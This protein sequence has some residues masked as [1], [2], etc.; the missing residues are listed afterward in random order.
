MSPAHDGL[1]SARESFSV[2]DYGESAARQ[3]RKVGARLTTREDS[4]LRAGAHRA[5]RGAKRMDGIRTLRLKT[6]LLLAVLWIEGV[7]GTCRE[8][9]NAYGQPE[10]GARVTCRDVAAQRQGSGG[11]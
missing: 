2:G 5:R 4:S 10:H 6:L 8:N 7:A 1:A 11:G 9:V 3:Y